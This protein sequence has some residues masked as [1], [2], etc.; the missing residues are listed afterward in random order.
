MYTVIIV[1]HAEEVACSALVQ[2]RLEWLEWLAW[3]LY[4]VVLVGWQ[5][6]IRGEQCASIRDHQLIFS[7]VPSASHLHVLFRPC[8]C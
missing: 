4:Q 2:Y 5:Y 6:V 3:G 8:N 7:D 1:V